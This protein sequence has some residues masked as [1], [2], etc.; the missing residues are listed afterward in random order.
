MGM[1]VRS[2][3]LDEVPKLIRR[4][5]M[6]GWVIVIGEPHCVENLEYEVYTPG[7]EENANFEALILPGFP[8]T[9]FYLV[10]KTPRLRELMKDL[11]DEEFETLLA[12]VFHVQLGENKCLSELIGAKKEMKDVAINRIIEWVKEVVGP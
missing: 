12:I 4:R 9:W 10:K 2:L 5:L 1:G 3:D 7:T 6:S 11:S 8:P